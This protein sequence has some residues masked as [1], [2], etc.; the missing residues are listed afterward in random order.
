MLGWLRSSPKP[1]I[2]TYDKAWTETRM[3][4][5]ADHFGIDR[6]R[7]A[8]VLCP[9][10]EDF[11]D[12]YS[13]TAEDVQR[14][15]LRLC[16]VLGIDPLRVELRLV[17]GSELPGAAGLYEPSKDG[18]AIISIASSTLDDFQ[19]VVSTLAHELAHE[20]LLGQGHLTAQTEDH[21]RVTDLL[22]VFLGLGV[23][24]ANATVTDGTIRT[25]NWE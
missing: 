17:D 1:P 25:G 10:R 19:G 21:E 5:L 9:V 23:F 20:L 4:W 18:P 11:P 2:E 6:M 16:G 12:P 3:L 7:N 14:I 13:A 24:T 15:M 8:K 22:P